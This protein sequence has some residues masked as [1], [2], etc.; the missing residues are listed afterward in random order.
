MAELPLRARSSP[1]PRPPPPASSLILHAACQH[2]AP[3][4]RD[5][6]RGAEG[7]AGSTGAAGGPGP[8]PGPPPAP[9]PRTVLQHPARGG[10]TRRRGR[11]LPVRGREPLAAP[12]RAGPPGSPGCALP[13]LP[14]SCPSLGCGDGDGDGRRGHFSVGKAHGLKF[15]REGPS[16]PRDLLP[17]CALWLRPAAGTRHQNLPHSPPQKG[18]SAPEPGERCRVFACWR[19]KPSKPQCIEGKNP[20]FVVPAGLVETLQRGL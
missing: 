4:R 10:G 17:V 20:S 1:P 19:D 7:S 8:P 6:P 18:S 13:P 12:G 16:V 9:R 5:A 11:G 2:R 3:R 14:E 15:G